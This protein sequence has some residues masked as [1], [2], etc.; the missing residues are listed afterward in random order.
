MGHWR[1]TVS[2]Y[3]TWKRRQTAAVNPVSM[4]G[5]LSGSGSLVAQMVVKRA[6]SGTA[7]GTGSLTGDATLLTPAAIF[8]GSLLVRVDAMGGTNLLDGNGFVPT[9]GGGV[10]TFN[11]LAGSGHNCVQ[12]AGQDAVYYSASFGGRGGVAFAGGASYSLFTN[13]SLSALGSASHTLIGVYSMGSSTNTGVWTAGNGSAS[14]TT[15]TI[16]QYSSVWWHGGAGDAPSTGAS[17]WSTTPYVTI[18]TWNSATTTSTLY[19]N[20][21]L[22]HSY[23]HGA[24]GIVAGYVMGSWYN[25]Y[26]SQASFDFAEGMIVSGVATAT[27]IANIT[28]YLRSKWGI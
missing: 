12:S 11:D 24:Y 3:G 25:A 6:I 8:G 15:S 16:G 17:S 14:L 23:T 27:Q 19:K 21:T 18:K 28:A 1:P 26:S 10:H 9:N 5:T 2:S 7:S 4:S 13:S 22:D 20:G